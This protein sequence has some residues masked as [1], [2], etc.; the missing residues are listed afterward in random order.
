[1]NTATE[2]NNEDFFLHFVFI[3]LSSEDSIHPI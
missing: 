1:M 2:T 3:I